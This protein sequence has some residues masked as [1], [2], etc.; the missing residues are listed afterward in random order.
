MSLLSYA[1]KI[2]KKLF[3]MPLPKGRAEDE[4]AGWHH[5]HDGHE[6]EWLQELVMDRE[7]WCAAV[8]GVTKSWTWLKRLAA[9]ATAAMRWLDG[10]TDS[11]DM[12]LGKLQEWWWTGKAGVL[13]SMGSQR[14]RHDWVTELNWKALTIQPKCKRKITAAILLPFWS[15][16]V[17]ICISKLR[18]YAS[19]KTSDQ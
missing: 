18:I 19:L 16:E 5:W 17:F 4:M 11:M 13:Q 2:T 14:V 7:G 12:S 8:H 3:I 10:I 1:C 6:F 9:A 15:T